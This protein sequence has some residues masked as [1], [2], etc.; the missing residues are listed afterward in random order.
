MRVRYDSHRVGSSSRDLPRVAHRDDD[1]LSRRREPAAG[2]RP[3][4]RRMPGTLQFAT[5]WDGQW[6][7]VINAGG[8]PSEIPRTD[9][10]HAQENAWAFM[11]AYPFLLRLFTVCRHPVPRRSPRSSRR[12]FARGGRAVS[13]GSWRASCRGFGA[14]RDGAVLLR[15]A[16]DHPAGVVRGVDAPLPALPRTAPARRP[17]VRL[18]V[19]VV[20]VMSLT[21]PSGLAFALC[22]LLHLVHR[23]VTAAATVPVAGAGRGRRRRAGRAPS[24]DRLAAHRLGGYRGVHRLYRHRVRLAARVRRRG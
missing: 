7:W 6:Y 22:L 16:V 2:E 24:P 23:F 10:G 8:Y 11:P 12:S 13:T 20:V 5:I 1:D 9:D 14:V 18:L 3:H 15:P 19:P 4:G 17:A 21:R